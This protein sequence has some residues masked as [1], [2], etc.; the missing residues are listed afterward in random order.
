MPGIPSRLAQPASTAAPAASMVDPAA[1]T[2]DPRLSGCPQGRTTKSH[3]TVPLRDFI[4]CPK[5]FLLLIVL[6]R[7]GF[8]PL[9]TEVFPQPE[10]SQVLFSGERSFYA[11]LKRHCH[12]TLNLSLSAVS[13]TGLFVMQMLICKGEMRLCYIFIF[14]AVFFLLMGTSPTRKSTLVRR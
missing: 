11:L 5:I 14:L 13:G 9:V 8:G 4:S 1:S 10:L 6:G 3:A 7:G 12:E 2:A